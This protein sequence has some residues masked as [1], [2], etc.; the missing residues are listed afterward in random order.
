MKL[1]HSMVSA[2][3]N[4]ENVYKENYDYGATFIYLYKSNDSIPFPKP[5][6]E[7]NTLQEHTYLS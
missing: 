7:M 4:R 5:I 2:V 6:M 3:T 1:C